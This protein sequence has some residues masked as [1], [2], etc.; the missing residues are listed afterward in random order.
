VLSLRPAAVGGLDLAQ[1]LSGWRT[2]PPDRST[3][4]ASDATRQ[5][6]FSQLDASF[7]VRDGVGH[8]TDLDG[9]SDFLRVAGEGT[10]DLAR[11]RID[12]ALRARI[13]NTASGRA[14]PEM[15]LLNGVTVPVGL[16]GPF[17][18]VQWQVNWPSVTAG[19]A[20]RSVPNVARGAVGAA[21][22]VVRGTGNLLRGAAGAVT[23]GARGAAS[24]APPPN[25]PPSPRR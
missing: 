2:A 1:T 15:V 23:G 8:S 11:A 12:Y 21:G 18:A 5:T 7:D 19:V 13:V 20:V 10:L 6:E 17:G 16:Q 4:V 14:G 9:R 3:T 22:G 25:P 24:P